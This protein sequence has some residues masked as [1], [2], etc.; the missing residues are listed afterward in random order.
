MKVLRVLRSHRAKV[1]D[2]GSN[3][4]AAMLQGGASLLLGHGKETV[5]NTISINP[6]V[7]RRFKRKHDIKMPLPS[8][9]IVVE[10]EAKAAVKRT[11]AAL[12][13]ARCFVSPI[14]TCL[15]FEHEKPFPRPDGYTPPAKRI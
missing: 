7:D 14:H 3:A 4:A 2:P 10:T 1:Q 12:M 9:R 5:I 8:G 6:A 15:G 13:P 11:P